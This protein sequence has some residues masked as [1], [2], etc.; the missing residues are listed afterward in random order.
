MSGVFTG[1]LLAAGWGTRLQPLT[2]DCPKPM[3]PLMD[4]PLALWA[5]AAMAEAGVSRIAYNTHPLRHA[6]ELFPNDLS[7]LGVDVFHSEEH[8][9]LGTGGGLGLLASRL[10]D[11]ADPLL[12]YNADIICSA[13]L[14]KLLEAH[15]S[16]NNDVTLLLTPGDPSNSNIWVDDDGGVVSVPS[17]GPEILAPRS[18]ECRAYAGIAA[19]SPSL[20]L[21]LP[22]TAKACWVRDG[23][24]HWLGAGAKVGSVLHRGIWADLGTPRRMVTALAELL[25][26]KPEQLH[27]AH[28]AWVEEGRQGSGWLSPRAGEVEGSLRGTWHVGAGASVSAAASLEDALLLGQTKAE[29]PLRCGVAYADQWASGED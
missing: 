7:A 18:A 12:I 15:R 21:R 23:L 29:Q 22:S 3:L 11:L 25:E 14:G 20:A 5:A 9:T 19:V 27:P 24:A 2:T 13:D 28:R 8:L 17:S 26:A 6:F 1:F 10:A 4:R 16:N